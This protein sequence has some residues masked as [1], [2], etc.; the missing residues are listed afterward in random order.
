MKRI[1]GKKTVSVTPGIYPVGGG[2]HVRG[3][4]VHTGRK[5]NR[6]FAGYAYKKADGWYCNRPGGKC[7]FLGGGLMKDAL[8]AMMNGGKR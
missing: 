1:V 2:K 3:Y 4:A 8:H 6:S 7:E 5:G